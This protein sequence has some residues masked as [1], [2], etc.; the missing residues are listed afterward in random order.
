MAKKSLF[1]VGDPYVGPVVFI[2]GWHFPVRDEV[3]DQRQPVIVKVE[4]GKERYVYGD[5][6]SPKHNHVWERTVAEVVPYSE[7]P[8]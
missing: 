2:D 5:Q 6:A 7:D 1:P 4:N 8:K 3:P